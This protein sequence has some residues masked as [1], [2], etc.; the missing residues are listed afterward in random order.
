MHD[1][2][3]A[4]LLSFPLRRRGTYPPIWHIS[5][6]PTCRDRIV[7]KSVGQQVE[8][9]LLDARA[10]RISRTVL[11]QPAGSAAGISIEGEKNASEK[12]DA[13]LPRS[14]ALIRA[15]SIALIVAALAGLGMVSHRVAARRAFDR[16]AFN[17]VLSVLKA[18]DR[19]DDG[20]VLDLTMRGPGSIP[21]LPGASVSE[22]STVQVRRWRSGD[23][24][25]RARND[26]GSLTYR[27]H[28]GSLYAS[29]DE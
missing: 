26:L 5:C 1:I 11:A 4:E 23:E 3:T 8:A 22:G 15:L 2:P 24:Y 27:F 12:R 21:G 10:E 29:E 7:T 18:L 16:I 28:D 20:T 17:D 13:P 9:A 6:C 25:V 19:L 14:H